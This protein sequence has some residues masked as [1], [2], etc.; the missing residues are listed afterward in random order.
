M[1]ESVYSYVFSIRHYAS[2]TFSAFLNL[3]NRRIPYVKVSSRNYS[4]IYARMAENVDE[5]SVFAYS[6]RINVCADPALE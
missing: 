5:Y 4:S 1:Y 2:N 6:R 3:P